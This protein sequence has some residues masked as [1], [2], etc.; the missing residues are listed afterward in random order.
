MIHSHIMEMPIAKNGSRYVITFP[1]DYSRGLHAGHCGVASICACV[2]GRYGVPVCRR[3]T[4][5][6]LRFRCP[7]SQVAQNAQ[8]QPL[9]L[10][11]KL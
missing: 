11:V 3:T 9:N 10:V 5:K 8:R 2:S 1:D 7:S 6:F 4:L